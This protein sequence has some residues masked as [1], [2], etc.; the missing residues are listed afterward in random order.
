MAGTAAKVVAL[1]FFTV[2]KIFCKS[3]EFFNKIRVEPTN[4]DTCKHPNP[5]EWCSGS[6]K[7]STSEFEYFKTWTMF[8]VANS[9]IEWLIPTP[10]GSDVVP[11][12]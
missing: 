8:L 10:L 4:N 1:Y 12:V 6:G 9:T 7:T 11:D 5:N 3:E 2:S